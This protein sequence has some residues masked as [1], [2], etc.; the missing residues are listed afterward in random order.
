MANMQNEKRQSKNVLRKKFAAFEAAVNRELERLFDKKSIDR[1]WR[2]E[3]PPRL[4]VNDNKYNSSP[5]NYCTAAEK[6]AAAKAYEKI[7]AINE[8]IKSRHSETKDQL[9]EIESQAQAVIKKAKAKLTADEFSL[10][11]S[12][13]NAS[14]AAEI[15]KHADVNYDEL[16]KELAQ[17]GIDTKTIKKAMPAI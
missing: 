2:R 7:E 5:L 9:H 3:S 8:S 13:V 4:S 6:R 12:I 17:I 15:R 1:R 16:F 11:V 14:E 10:D